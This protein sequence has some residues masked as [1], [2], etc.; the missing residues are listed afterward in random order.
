MTPTEYE[1]L[2]AHT[3]A[4]YDLLD[5]FDRLRVLKNVVLSHHERMDGAGYPQGL[6]GAEIPLIARIVSVADAYDA[7]TT[8]RSYRRGRASIDALEELN[9]CA[10][11]QF[12]ETVVS[13]FNRV[14]EDLEVPSFPP[15]PSANAA[16]H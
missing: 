15:A 1:S 4:G 16:A 12:D 6:T 11:A 5:R 3:V 9:R 14:F 13:A 2:K 7:M 8:D 10:G